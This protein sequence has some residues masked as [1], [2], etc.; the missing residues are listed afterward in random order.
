LS[1]GQLL[2][3]H[4]TAAGFSQ[5]H[6][7]ALARV[8]VE[9]I[10]A[11]ERGTRRAPYRETVAALAEALLLD[12]G[13]RA[14]LEAAVSTARSRGTRIAT[15]TE[16]QTNQHLPLQ[17]TTLIGREHDIAAITALLEKSRLVTIIGSGG[18]GKTR[19]AIEVAA[20][21]PAHDRGDIRFVDLSRLT[22]GALVA[23]AV[24]TTLE[25]PDDNA[26]SVE[27]LVQSL[28]SS[29]AFLVLDNCEHLI[30][31]VALLV[32]AI[33]ISC[34]GIALLAASRE[35]I[36]VNGESVYRL[37]SLELPAEMPVSLEQA[38]CYAGIELFIQRSTA[39]DHGVAFHD[40]DISA[41][42]EICRRLDAIP[43]AIE[44]A[45]ARVAVL[46]LDALRTRIREGITIIAGLRN[47]PARQ[48]TMQATIAWSYELLSLDEQRMLRVLSLFVGGFTLSATES[49]CGAGEFAGNDII[50][51]IS[52]LV[53]KSL[54]NVSRAEGL[55]RY[56]LLDSVRSFA[57]E[58]LK[59]AGE[60][61]FFSE[62]HAEWIAAFADWVDASR[63]AF[64]ERR[65]RT[66]VDP[67]LENARAALTWALEQKTEAGAVLAGRIVGGLRTIWLTSGRRAE[68][69]R[70]A[71]AVLEIIDEQRHP[72][73]VAPLLRALVQTADGAELFALAERATLVFEK[74]GDRLG[75]A[76]LQSHVSTMR[77]RRGFIDEAEVAIEKAG[78]IFAAGDLPRLIPYVVFL[79]NR[80]VLRIDQVRYAEARADLEEATAILK[81][82]G[83]ED[84]LW[85]QGLRADLAF[86]V[87]EGDAAIGILEDPIER[88]LKLGVSRASHL[89]DMH[90]YLAIY[91][92]LAGHDDAE[93]RTGREALLRAT[94]FT[95]DDYRIM[96]I[97]A[98]A[99]LAA[100][101]GQAP[102]AARLLGC[103]EASLV[104]A[105]SGDD[106]YP[107]PSGPA[108]LECR[109]Q[110]NKI[111]DMALTPEEIER[112]KS[113]GRTFSIETAM[114]EA[115]QV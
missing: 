37:P 62:R 53:D 17:A 73:I 40:M 56:K 94:T 15:V 25:L 43:L 4:R 106:F 44:L 111:L 76:M 79:Q 20:R 97:R 21:M 50:G 6:L 81:S 74:I 39:S 1:F 55:R 90:V 41:I 59:A 42:V 8:S 63:A 100:V 13:D 65:L 36:A 86:V 101:R 70:W 82:L 67:E 88:A 48:Q 71:T 57:F 98:M 69:H 28:R 29:K 114:A 92:V 14:K 16:P 12:A 45:A 35:R 75:I 93:Y 32:S 89:H 31:D 47:L 68:C 23:G 7:A 27:D 103:I 99:L 115:Q 72:R 34:P 61:A 108:Y 51:L 107:L 66:K 84:A 105:M 49:V 46:G 2:R 19:T 54:V 95:A 104:R 91:R 58:R 18:V 30:G 109:K 52:S 87:G 112:F 33:L 110:L 113:Q 9:S 80:L 3:H 11:L 60:V 10:G 64:P 85:L 102:R 96:T 24:A 83:D 22:D 5:E 78:A 26:K 38:R 77:R